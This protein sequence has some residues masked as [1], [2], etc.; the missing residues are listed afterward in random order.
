MDAEAL[1]A[2]ARW[3]RRLARSLVRDDSVAE[4]LVQET[5]IAAL[6]GAPAD[7]G[8]LRPWLARVVR[9]FARQSHR[10]AAN[11]ARQEAQSARPERTPSTS[12]TAERLEAQRLLVEALESL[13][14]PYRTTVTLRYLEGLSAAKIAR[15]QGIPAGTVR[16]RLKHG[17]D[18]LRTRLDGRCG[19]E[20]RNWALALVP[21]LARPPLVAI[22]TQGAASGAAAAM[23]GVMM[24]NTI[25]KVGIAAALVLTASVGVWVVVD[26]PPETLAP[27]TAP[28]PVAAAPD[29]AAPAVQSPENALAS[30]P[31]VESREAAHGP[32]PAAIV[33][34]AAPV[35]ASTDARVEVRFLDGAGR[36]V[37]GVALWLVSFEDLDPA[38][39]DA[40]GRAHIEVELPKPVIST[41]VR[42]SRAGFATHFGE[43]TLTRGRTSYLGDVRLPP[44]G[45]V[46][47]IVF[48]PSGAPAA[49]AKVI[50]A[51]PEMQRGAEEGRL[52]GPVGT[53]GV[54]HGVTLADG[55]FRV[56]GVRAASVR[57]WAGG[58]DTRWTFTE[59][60]EVP[61]NGV[62]GGVEMRLEAL[63][64]Q[65]EISGIVL[66]PAGDPVPEA[67]VRYTGKSGGSTWS[68]SFPAGK[69]GRFRHRIQI[70]GLHDF[71]AHDPAGRWPDASALSVEP[72]THDLALQFP[73]PRRILVSVHARGGGPL[74]EFGAN[75]LSAD[76]KRTL[77]P[78]N[79]EAHDRGRVELLL[80]SEPFVIDVRARGHGNALLGPW[81]PDEAPASAEC[82]LDS[83]PGVRGRVLADGAPVAG[84]KLA[85]YE[86]A[87]EQARIE[88]NGFLTRLHPEPEDTTTSDGE[89][90]F[91]LDPTRPGGAD[92][93][94]FFQRDAKEAR[95][96][97]VLCDANGWALAEFSPL[98]VD[99]AV[100]ADGIE[101]AL[102]K[103]GAIEGRVLTAPGKEPAGIVV[104]IDRYDGKPRTQRVGPDGRFRF[105]RL[106]PG[107]YR[108]ARADAELNPG[109]NSTSWSSGGGVHAEYPTNTSVADGETTRFDLD[110]RDDQ[111]CVLIAQV[112]VNG[113]PA[114]GWTAVLRPEEGSTTRK[115]PGGAVD[116]QGRL[117][118]E[119][120]DPA[121]A[122]LVL[123]PPSDTGRGA[124]FEL[125][126]DLH[127]GD[128]AVPVDLRVGAVH[129]RC[130]AAPATSVIV[131]DPQPRGAIECSVEVH[132]DADGR[133]EMPFVL[134]GPARVARNEVRAEGMTVGPI[135]ET[136]VDVPMGGTVDV[137]V[138]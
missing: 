76:K 37:A 102:V 118:L 45:S 110:L 80:P 103:G 79:L 65:D 29:R 119:L 12:E 82:T 14:E 113:G 127:R 129:G 77:R 101:I 126:V 92:S 112:S 1:L 93:Q 17:I 53:E 2:E 22:A 52:I 85:L 64:V 23:E 124:T 94:R 111:P 19:G 114:T 137:V 62:R 83:L 30:A 5:W 46:A 60:I 131:F 58:E 54:P 47:G 4:D 11:R 21:L 116:A 97:A 42:A 57:V 70:R 16:W 51:S 44:G 81:A 38:T 78:G 34:R 115:C 61:A 8:R 133:F 73:Q 88:R 9:N 3:V 32:A 75:I 25:T 120:P 39:S 104:G 48:A 84:A 122:Q 136:H 138:P 59:P 31:A 86:L 24:M 123:E 71:Q 36:P 56:D 125:R 10:G 72:G 41:P 18:E 99:P 63:Q 74:V 50:V 91:Q 20:R 96:M 40:D 132:I 35:F 106:T 33:E 55:S 98:E 109:S 105:D 15:K 49:G 13:A 100:G 43:V 135:A 89:G 27:A 134:A 6:E 28:E 90:Y 107:G 95:A 69:D 87:G 67:E 7:G 66:S 68:G 26:R 117:R 130:A 121:A 128:N 108:V